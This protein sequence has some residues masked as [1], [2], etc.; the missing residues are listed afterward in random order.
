MTRII[1][2]FLT[3]GLLLAST[4]FMG[5]AG[6][7]H[8]PESEKRADCENADNQGWVGYNSSRTG[9]YLYENVSKGGW[10][11]PNPALAAL[12]PH[13]NRA[14]T[15]VVVD[16]CEGE[17]WDGQD[18]VNNEGKNEPTTTS[19]TACTPRVTESAAN[20]FSLTNCQRADINDN[21][22]TPLN[23]APL[24]LR[25]SGKGNGNGGYQELYVG[26]DILLVG[27][28]AV[29]AG[30]CSD[31]TQ[32]LEGS[33]SCDSRDS[34]THGRQTRGAVYLRDNTPQNI[35]AQVVSSAG[36]T[37]GEAG[38]GD[39]SQEK[40]N[41]GVEEGRRDLCTRDNTAITV[42]LLS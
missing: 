11:A 15:A 3:A 2:V 7:A 37:R 19:D 30:T 41:Q 25:L 22:D 34:A 32:G 29:Y 24:A 5:T 9:R 27:R 14:I 42:D 13:V 38:D 36:I 23:R 40:Y 39:C 35:L 21:S 17:H 12:E 20:D 1:L 26:L 8:D 31:N 4:P 10:K 6:A 16:N 33:A 28:A 18:T